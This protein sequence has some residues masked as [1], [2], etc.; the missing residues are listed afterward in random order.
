MPDT[1]CHDQGHDL[2]AGLVPVVRVLQGWLQPYKTGSAAPDTPWYPVG[3]HRDPTPHTTTPQA[4]TPLP[5]PPA[6]TPTRHTGQ[7]RQPV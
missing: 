7:S 4:A 3:C 6:T 5:E 1:R 2:A